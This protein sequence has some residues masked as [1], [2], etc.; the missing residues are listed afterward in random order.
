MR[1]LKIIFSLPCFPIEL[2]FFVY[3]T[4]MSLRKLT[5]DDVVAKGE[6]MIVDEMTEKMESSIEKA[7]HYRY[8]FS[9]FCWLYIIKEII[10]TYQP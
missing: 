8:A 4:Y 5:R 10:I 3:T 9:A 7:K 1:I 2:A 6:E